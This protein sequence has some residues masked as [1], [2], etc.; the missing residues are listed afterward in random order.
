MLLNQIFAAERVMSAAVDCTTAC[1]L[2]RI[3]L[4]LDQIPLPGN[5][6]ERGRRKNSKV[7]DV[8]LITRTVAQRNVTWRRMTMH[9]TEGRGKAQGGEAWLGVA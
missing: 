2:E 4:T 7:T 1:L 3:C 6:L 5:A 9:R 8:T